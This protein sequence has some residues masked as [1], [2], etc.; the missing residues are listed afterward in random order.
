MAFKPGDFVFTTDGED[1]PKGH[2]RMRVIVEH[3][4]EGYTCATVEG[5]LPLIFREDKI[6]LANKWEVS[7]YRNVDWKTGK[8]YELEARGEN[9]GPYF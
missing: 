5:G 6:R 2:P 9:S 3:V 1:R 7:S 8:E 4:G